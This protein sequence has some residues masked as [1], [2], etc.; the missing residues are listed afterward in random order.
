MLNEF[1]PKVMTSVLRMP[2]CDILCHDYRLKIFTCRAR[3]EQN[4]PTDNTYIIPFCSR[5]IMILRIF[6]ERRGIFLIN[7]ITARV[8]WSLSHRGRRSVRER[9]LGNKEGNPRARRERER[10][11][12]RRA[13]NER[14]L[15]TSP[16]LLPAQSDASRRARM[17]VSY[18]ICA[19]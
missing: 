5:I 2:S 11:T 12:L 16:L 17:H 14:S 19:Q 3:L 7:C 9:G 18:D 8:S 6:R 4:F 1:S 15:L 10:E 13:F